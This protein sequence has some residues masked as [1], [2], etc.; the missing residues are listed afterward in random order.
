[1]IKIGEDYIKRIHHTDEEITINPAELPMYLGDSVELDENVSF[2]RVFDLIIS[3]KEIFDVV[4]G[5]AKGFF[6]IDLYVNEYNKDDDDSESGDIDYLEVHH[7]Y[8]YWDYEK[9]VKIEP[10]TS[11]HGICENYTDEFQKE[12][13]RMGIGISFTPINQLKKYRIKINNEFIIQNFDTKQSPPQ[14]LTLV[15]GVTS[16]KL[17]DFIAAILHEITWHGAP[18]ERDE[19][20]EDLQETSR[21][22]KSGE[23]ELFQ[24]II[25]E[26]TGKHYLKDKD[27]NLRPFF[28]EDEK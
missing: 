17:Y 13:C 20:V 12:P 10:Y 6:P 11:F 19:V 25:D 2:K 16:M 22:I 14:L 21:R 8:D 3:N 26:E 9:D 23:E 4:F 24:W 5:V 7:V 28:D 1:M 15:K 27:G 18:Q